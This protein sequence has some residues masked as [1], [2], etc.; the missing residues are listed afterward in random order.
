M[1]PAG[2]LGLNLLFVAALAPAQT[3]S[4]SVVSGASLIPDAPLAADMMVIASSTAIPATPAALSVSV[5]D[6][7]ETSRD[8]LVIAAA[9]DRIQFVIPTGTANGPATIT[10]RQGESTIAAASVNIARVAPGLFTAN[11]TGGGAPL[12][13]A[14]ELRSDGS[15]LRHSLFEP[16]PGQTKFEAR[17]F[18]LEWDELTFHLELFGTGLRAARAEQILASVGGVPVPVRSTLQL[19]DYPGIDQMIVGPLPRTL[20]GRRGLSELE[21]SI[22]GISSNKVTVAPTFPHL[23]G[24]GVRAGLIEANSEMS[25][26]G[27]N[28]SVYVLGGYPAS[29]NTVATVQVYDTA[30]NTWRLTTPLPVPVNHAMP[31]VVN[32]KLYLIGGQTD[33]GAAYVNVVQVYDPATQQWQRRANMPTSRSA[34]AA[35]VIDGKIYVAG[36]RPPRGADFAIYDPDKDEW[37]TLPN[38]PTQRNH[39]AAVEVNGKMYVMGGRF[40]GGFQSVQA[41][42][43]EIYDPASSAWTKGAPMLKPRGGLNAVAAYGCIHVFGGE[44]ATGVHGDHDLYNPVTNTWEPLASMPTPIHGVTGLTFIDGLIY[45]PGGGVMQGGSSGSRLHQVYRPNQVC[46]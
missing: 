38:L 28:G 22:D 44:H 46:R 42:A 23:A 2:R 24:W 1:T 3:P 9:P 30:A 25:V 8:A 40:D 4:M 45:L 10:V 43:V 14:L 19:P 21:I 26:A 41:D 17:P 18:D 20:A 33:A 12:G 11:E 15:E 6:S 34:G 29:R 36:G 31:A 35:A 32:E 39:L 16:Y 5:R 37:T 7:T 13:S 27:M